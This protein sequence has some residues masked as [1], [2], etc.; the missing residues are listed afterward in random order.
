MSGYWAVTE[1]ST[2]E[3]WTKVFDT[4]PAAQKFAGERAE[5]L[6]QQYHTS[7]LDALAKYVDVEYRS[8]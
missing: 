6:A 3:G 7:S 8:I 4:Y 5:T 1:W 2:R